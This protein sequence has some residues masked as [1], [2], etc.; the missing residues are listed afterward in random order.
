MTKTMNTINQNILNDFSLNLKKNKY[1]NKLQDL[2]LEYCTDI[3]GEYIYLVKIRIKKSIR[4]SG[5]GSLILS[6]L[7]NFANTHNV[8]IILYPSDTLGSDINR[9][10]EFYIKHGF[11]LIKKENDNYMIYNPKQIVHIT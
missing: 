1:K 7:I 10:H 4:N 6:E 11:F 2:I 9:L 8:R 3:K 5:Y